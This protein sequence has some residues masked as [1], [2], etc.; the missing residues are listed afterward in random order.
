MSGESREAQVSRLVLE[1][2]QNV[3]AIA[4]P[5]E[6]SLSLRDDLAI[7]SL[8]LVSLTVRLGDEIG[9]DVLQVG[10]ELANVRTVAD[11]VGVAEELARFRRAQETQENGG[12]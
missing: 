1:Y 8:S 2:A 11:L 5:L 12:A 9:V 4:M 6:P 7:E 3:P 10:L